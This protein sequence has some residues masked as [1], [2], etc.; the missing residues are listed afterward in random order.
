MNKIKIIAQ[1]WLKVSFIQIGV[2][3][4][5]SEYF[6]GSSCPIVKKII[7]LKNVIKIHFSYINSNLINKILI[8]KIIFVLKVIFSINYLEVYGIFERKCI[9]YSDFEWYNAKNAKNRFIENFKFCRL[10]TRDK[11]LR[12]RSFSLISVTYLYTRAKDIFGVFKIRYCFY[13]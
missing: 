9:P 11:T 5:M 7:T 13:S 2:K 1:I 6:P 3:K 4:L 10:Q 12:C 8:G